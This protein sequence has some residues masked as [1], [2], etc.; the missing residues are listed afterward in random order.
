MTNYS[1]LWNNEYGENYAALPNTVKIGADYVLL[2]TA[3]A[4]RPYGRGV[5]RAL[6]KELVGATGANAV[7]NHKRV[8]AV[9][10]LDG[11]AQGGVRGIQTF[12]GISRAIN[13]GDKTR[14]V[15]A[16][17]MSSKP[18]YPIDKSGNGGGA[19]LGV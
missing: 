15:N 2:K 16:L 5:M 9:R 8:Q 12:T 17:T 3:F 18:A 14:L 4:K 10:N 11:N 13:A 1:G 19:K 7:S 6:L